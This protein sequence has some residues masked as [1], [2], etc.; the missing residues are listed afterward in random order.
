M[1]AALAVAL[2]GGAQV[3]ASV[4]VGRAIPSLGQDRA[5]DGMGA[6]RTIPSRRQAMAK[7]RH[8]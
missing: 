2:T 5:K 8:G 3:R 7:R 4:V 1:E 6:N